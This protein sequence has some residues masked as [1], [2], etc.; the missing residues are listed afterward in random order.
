MNF[1]SRQLTSKELYETVK[2]VLLGEQNDRGFRKY[3]QSL[4]LDRREKTNLH[5]VARLFKSLGIEHAIATIELS[6]LKKA[7]M[8]C[9]I[10]I[11]KSDSFYIAKLS[12]DG[13]VVLYDVT[14]KTWH[15]DTP[16]LLKEWEGDCLL[17]DL[18]TDLYIPKV[19]IDFGISKAALLL[20]GGLLTAFLLSLLLEQPNLWPV[21]LANSI[22]LLTTILIIMQDHG[23]GGW[24]DEACGLISKRKTCNTL[25]R[26]THASIGYGLTWSSAGLFYYIA[27]LLMAVFGLRSTATL[28][29]YLLLNV[30]ACTFIPYSLYIQA[31]SA[32]VWCSLCLLVLFCL[33]TSGCCSFLL[34]EGIAFQ[35]IPEAALPV[36]F[37]IGISFIITLLTE[38]FLRAKKKT[39]RAEAVSAVLLKPGV[40]LLNHFQTLST[41]ELTM[42]KN[43][44]WVFILSY[45]CPYCNKR[46][47]EA[48]TGIRNGVIKNYLFVITHEM[49]ESPSTTLLSYFLIAH[50]GKDN[51]LSLLYKWFNSSKDEKT[52]KEIVG[53]W[54]PE[55]HAIE[56]YYKERKWINNSGITIYPTVITNCKVIPNGLPLNNFWGEKASQ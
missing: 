30:L 29:C 6:L 26:S 5:R 42:Q 14:K 35:T 46:F 33:L 32:K 55:D 31:Y 9:L 34:I 37:S 4:T 17:F 39:I 3:F 25:S 7:P 48:Y 49:E 21:A 53:D 1:N 8:P 24:V 22:G 23:M 41:D 10:Y 18:P 56:T 40:K 11:R 54:Q 12:D 38:H 52:T 50:R 16:T 13:V 19:N 15:K 51:Y 47:N 36:I 44:T 45:H 43:P 20:F 27:L 2:L 28:Q